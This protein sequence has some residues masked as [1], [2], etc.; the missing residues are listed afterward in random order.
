M[1]TSL[2]HLPDHKQRELAHIVQLISDTLIEFRVSDRIHGK[3]KYAKPAADLKDPDIIILFGSY[4]RDEQVDDEYVENGVTYTYRS[5]FDILVVMETCKM[6]R[7][8]G[9]FRRVAEQVGPT[10]V[11][12][13]AH[14]PKYVNEKIEEGQYLFTDIYNEGIVL[15]DSKRAKLAEPRKLEPAERKAAAEKYF[16]IWS[17]LAN[18]FFIDFENAFDRG[19]FKIAAFY[20]HQAAEHLYGTILLV[21]TNYKPKSHNLEELSRQAGNLDGS[22][23]P[24]FPRASDEELRRFQLLKA[25]Y[26]DARYDDEYVITMEDLDY[27]AACVRLLRDTTKTV[28]AKR[29]ARF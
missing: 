22:F 14:T 26:I 17:T 3:G 5:D 12:I 11:R 23:M 16:K 8:F 28:C 25:A 6:A 4:A 24:I 19:S 29:I 9:V 15:Y 1:K 2:D 13:I 10:P 27:L 7:D 18:E 20:L 21:F